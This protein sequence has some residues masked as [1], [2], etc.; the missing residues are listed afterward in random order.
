MAWYVDR[1]NE[2][3]D[4]D[5]VTVLIYCNKSRTFVARK[6]RGWSAEAYNTLRSIAQD[7]NA[8]GYEPQEVQQM[9]V[10]NLKQEDMFG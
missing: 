6:D 2:G 4:G 1:R 9:I 5:E 8:R 3:I 10:D 7:Y